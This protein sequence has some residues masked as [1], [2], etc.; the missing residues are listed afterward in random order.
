M[1][2]YNVEV[3]LGCN[4]HF[5][6]FSYILIYTFRNKPYL[7]QGRSPVSIR[8]VIKKKQEYDDKSYYSNDL[9]E[10]ITN[11]QSLTTQGLASLSSMQAKVGE[12]N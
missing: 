10:L 5:A 6:Y 1:I 11:K 2:V 8:S 12:S 7:Y 9:D 3:N 4:L